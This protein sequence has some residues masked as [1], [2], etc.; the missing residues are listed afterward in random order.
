MFQFHKGSINTHLCSQNPIIGLRFNSIKVQLILPEACY[1]SVNN[2]F[3]FHKGSINTNNSSFGRLNQHSFNS[4]KVQLILFCGL[5]DT[6]A[7]SSFN[8][9]KVQLI[10]ILPSLE[11]LRQSMFQFHK[12]SINTWT[13]ETVKANN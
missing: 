7:F 4:I 10:L 6:P 2:T 11:A 3:Q 13:E 5:F 8:S 12:G 1:D 9:I